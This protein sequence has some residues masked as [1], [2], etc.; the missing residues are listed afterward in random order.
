MAPAPGC[1]PALPAIEASLA[2]EATGLF[3]L[4]EHAARDRLT[5]QRIT[6]RRRMRCLLRLSANRK[7]TVSSILA[8]SGKRLRQRN[9]PI[10]IVHDP[11]KR[12]QV[13]RLDQTHIV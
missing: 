9:P 8:H 1:D 12:G 3:S 10:Q 6:T 7:T 11:M 4:R 2:V 13:N 5:R